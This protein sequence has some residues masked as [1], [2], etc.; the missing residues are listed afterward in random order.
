MPRTFTVIV[1]PLLA[2]LALAQ[3]ERM[4]AG[5][6]EGL[7]EKRVM[8]ELRRGSLCHPDESGEATKHAGRTPA[9]LPVPMRPSACRP[10][11]QAPEIPAPPP[12]PYFACVPRFA[13]SPPGRVTDNAHSP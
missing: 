13:S 5:P 10:S 11:R 3:P 8:D 1:L 6:P 4:V 9:A 2:K 7:L 12:S